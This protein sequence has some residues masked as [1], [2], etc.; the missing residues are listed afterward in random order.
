MS[1]RHTVLTEPEW[2]HRLGIH[3]HVY[4]EM[5]DGNRLWLD[6]SDT[7][8]PRGPLRKPWVILLSVVDHLAEWWLRKREWL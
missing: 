6:L 8:G 7:Y 2:L 4:R 5:L 3:Y 1:T